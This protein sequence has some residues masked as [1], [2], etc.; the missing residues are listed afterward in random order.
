MECTGFLLVTVLLVV[1]I[2]LGIALTGTCL[3]F[4]GTQE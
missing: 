3:V 4:Q 2:P 1:C